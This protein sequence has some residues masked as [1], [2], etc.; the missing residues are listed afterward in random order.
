MKMHHTIAITLFCIILC[1]GSARA[2]EENANTENSATQNAPAENEGTLSAPAQNTSTENAKAEKAGTQTISTENAKAKNA[3]TGDAKTQDL[4]N[5][6]EE[7]EDKLNKLTEESSARKKLEITE[8]EKQEQEKQVLEAVG[9]EYTTESKH[10]L[11]INY[12]ASYSYSPGEAIETNPLVVNDVKDHTFKHTI[13]VGYAV[14]DNLSVSM[15][16]PFIYRYYEMGTANQ[17]DTTGIGDISLGLGYQP[18]KAKAG[19]VNTSLGVSTW[20]PTGSSP[21][22][23][24]SDTE[25]ST[26]SGS[27]G[28]SV[29]GSF[30]KQIDPLVAFWNIGYTYTF[31]ITDVEH[32][33]EDSYILNKVLPGESYTLGGGIAYAMSYKVSINIGFSYSYQKSSTYKYENSPSDVKSGDAISS[34]LSLGLGWRLSDKTTLSFGLGYG[35][36]GSGFS[37]S[38]RVP[39][40]FVL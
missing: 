19:E 2:Q 22:E 4:L 18:Y 30:S 39:F 28:F 15:S 24:N 14:L 31:P 17:I 35:L 34:G 21:Y 8:E 40:S 13:D 11:S 32:Y 10:T 16:L 20:L 37:L 23:I 26:G 38:F 27:H 29:S 1:T 9:D 5:K 3:N 36:T 33:V 25:L 6:I 7:L 12:S